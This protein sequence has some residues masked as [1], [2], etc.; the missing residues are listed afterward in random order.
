MADVLGAIMVPCSMDS[1]PAVEALFEGATSAF[2]NYPHALT[3]LSVAGIE[4]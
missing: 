3:A 2:A 1:M 4:G